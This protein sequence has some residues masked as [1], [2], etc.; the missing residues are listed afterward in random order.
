M[1]GLPAPG[2]STLLLLRLL[3]CP[4]DADTWDQFVQRYSGTIY[5]WSCR[6]GLQD[7]DARDVTQNVFAALLRG[8]QTYDR[9]QGRF[10]TWLY[11]VVE[12]CVR[13]WC[14]DSE[15][16]Q[17]KG[18]EA[19]R[20]LLASEPAR[21]DLEARLSEEFDLELL[22]VAEM[23]VR[24]QV[25]PQTWAAYQLRC[26]ER[27]TLRQAAERIGIPAG[28]ASKYALRVRNMVTRQIALLEGPNGPEEN[29]GT[30][31]QHDPLPAGGKMAAVRSRPAEP[32]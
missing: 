26:K 13:D 32:A 1:S 28:H 8:L 12:N 4:A 9:A 20:L 17:E 6:H 16:R 21:S 27:L 18:T 15:Q 5:R 19:V 29:R 24:L 3:A 22:E 31:C 25:A 30:E 14:Q 23:N 7:A 2:S 10:R 11:R